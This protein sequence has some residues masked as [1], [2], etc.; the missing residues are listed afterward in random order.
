MASIVLTIITLVVLGAFMIAGSD[1]YAVVYLWLVGLGTL[2]VLVLQFSGAAAV[3]GFFLRRKERNVWKTMVAPA[4]G[5][6]GLLLAIYLAFKNFEALAGTSEGVAGLLPWLVPIALAAGLIL[7]FIRD[8]QGVRPDLGAESLTEVGAPRERQAALTP[9]GA[10]GDAS[11]I[12]D[13][14]D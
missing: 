6:L 13:T 10:P 12:P 5:G 7:G 3:I 11:A 4:L 8:R 2:G 14:T 9:L 1:P